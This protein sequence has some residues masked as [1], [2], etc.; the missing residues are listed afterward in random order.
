MD[1][2]LNCEG[3]K[4]YFSLPKGWNVLCCQDNPPVSGAAD[5]LKEIKT[6]GV[7]PYPPYLIQIKAQHR[8]S[9]DL[10]DDLMA[11]QDHRF[12]RMLVAHLDQQSQ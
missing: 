3:Q 1:Y 10:V 8:A 5:P 6:A 2:F 11:D 12:F 9:D 4:T 7:V